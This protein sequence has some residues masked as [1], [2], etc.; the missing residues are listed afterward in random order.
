MFHIFDF[1][2]TLR[3][4]SAGLPKSRV[5]ST[6]HAAN[7]SRDHDEATRSYA[8]DELDPK[9]ASCFRGVAAESSARQR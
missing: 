7:L 4:E 5:L 6:S 9:C 1:N 3:I 2:S 8:K